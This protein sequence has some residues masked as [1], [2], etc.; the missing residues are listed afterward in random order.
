MNKIYLS[1]Y[2]IEPITLDNL[3]R[4]EDVFYCNDEYYLIT[5]GRVATKNDCI[6]TIEYYIDGMPQNNFHNIGISDN[7]RPVACLFVIEGYPD[8]DT[9]WL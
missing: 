5:D 6:E 8:T 9:L 4:Y 7:G 1:G 3:Y 2:K